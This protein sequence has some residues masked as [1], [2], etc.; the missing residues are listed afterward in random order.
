MTKNRNNVLKYKENY[1]IEIDGCPSDYYI[2]RKLCMKLSDYQEFAVESY[3][4]VIEKDVIHFTKYE[5]AR[6]WLDRVESTFLIDELL[7]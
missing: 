2:S 6:D 3:N 7:K 1:I 5:H 4:A